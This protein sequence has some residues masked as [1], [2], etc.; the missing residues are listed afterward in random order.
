MYFN[1]VFGEASYNTRSEIFY[2]G[3][4][5]DNY[6]NNISNLFILP[7]HFLNKLINSYNLIKSEYIVYL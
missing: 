4:Y 1:N 7:R 6:D 5:C 2:S 3:V